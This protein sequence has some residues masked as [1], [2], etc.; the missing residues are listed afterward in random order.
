MRKTGIA[1]ADVSEYLSL[2]R[3]VR[4]SPGQRLWFSYDEGSDIL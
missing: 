3:A 2:V 4:I 1:L